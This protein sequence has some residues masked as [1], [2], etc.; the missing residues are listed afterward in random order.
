MA[1][2]LKKY[3]SFKNSIKKLKPPFDIYGVRPTFYLEGEERTLT[4][5][6][7]LCSIAMIGLLGWLSVSYFINMFKDSN[8]SV[9]YS[10]E[11]LE[12]FPFVDLKEKKQVFVLTPIYGDCNRFKGQLEHFFRIEY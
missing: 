10:K 2:S 9:E 12:T 3:K 5:I 7:C 6:G 11:N 8:L 1:K 4:W